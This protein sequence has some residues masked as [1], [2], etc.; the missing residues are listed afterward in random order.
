MPAS[1]K[2]SVII[3]VKNG[4]A[5]FRRVLQT[6]L[7]QDLGGAAFEVI[8]IDSGSSDGSDKWVEEMA[9]NHQ[10]LKL[11][12]IKP[13]EFCHGRTRNVGASLAKGE[14]LAFLTHDA[15]PVD[16]CW[17]A[18]LIKPL[19]KDHEVAGVFGKH[20]PY[21]DCDIFEKELLSRHF[22]NF[23]IETTLFSIDDMDRYKKDASYRHY[24]CFYSNNSSAMRKSLWE[25]IP[26]P[27]VDFAEDQLWA[28]TIL[29]KGY[30][31]AYT[32]EAI[33]YHSHHYPICEQ[34]KRYYDD[35]KGWNR[36]YGN[37]PV[38]TMWALPFHVIMHW[39]SDLRFLMTQKV[40]SGEKVK[41]AF[42]SLAKN[43]NR[44]LGGY[45]SMKSRKFVFLDRSLSRD[46][47][48][49]GKN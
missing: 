20:I 30:K 40:S 45:L 28:K 14:Y 2:A 37:V 13:E 3:P 11:I 27:D 39:V 17:L 29:E 43:T 38:K 35:F 46:Y 34:L 26:Y 31:K 47:R 19:E 7:E 4:G 16:R 6:V 5:L 36:V 9:K 41:W 15:L 18:N 24:L 48:L 32:P 8:I 44:Y 23:G 1:L 33:V 22:E 12:K 42:Y 10:G 25:K 49:R 21:E